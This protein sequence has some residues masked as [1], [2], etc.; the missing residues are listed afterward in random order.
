MS[1]IS[2]ADHQ[3][4]RELLNLIEKKDTPRTDTGQFASQ[5][6]EAPAP[7]E[8]EQPE[9]LDVA[10]QEDAPEADDVEIASPEDTEP[11]APAIDPPAGLTADE[12]DVFRNSPPEVQ[13]AWARREQERQREFRRWQNDKAEHDKALARDREALVQQQQQLAQLLNE[14]VST[15]EAEFQKKFGDIKDPRELLAEPMRLLEYN[16]LLTAIGQERAQ[17]DAIQRQQQA[18][19]EA[20]L[21]QHRQ[22]ENEKIRER[23]KLDDKGAAEFESQVVGYLYENLRKEGMED[24]RIQHILRATSAFEL[25]MAYKAMKWDKAEA[26]RKAVEK[27]ASPVPKVIRPGSKPDISP[28]QERKKQAFQNLRKTGDLQDAAAW[29][30]TQI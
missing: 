12:I 18:E 17:R 2:D 26:K 22:T 6:E 15:T 8:I 19:Q 23:L 7:E 21:Q 27:T 29:F 5:Q 14:R 24:G 10:P 13:N 1:G 4:G 20:R 28:V 11:Q 16:T 25:E 3:A 30:R 9:A